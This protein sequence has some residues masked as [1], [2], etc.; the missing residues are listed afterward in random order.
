M[1]ASDM[2]LLH[3]SG[4]GL[5]AESHIDSSVTHNSENMEATQRSID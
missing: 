3:V 4:K 5:E 1:Q 2:P